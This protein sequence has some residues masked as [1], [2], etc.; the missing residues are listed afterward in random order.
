[1]TD[2]KRDPN[3]YADDPERLLDEK[4]A[5]HFLGFS[6]RALQNW[7]VRGG[8]PQYVKCKGKSVRYRRRD[9]IEWSESQLQRNTAES[10]AA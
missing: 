10:D 6:G 2:I 8:G 3:R 7:R 4:D 9:L 1:M 5:A